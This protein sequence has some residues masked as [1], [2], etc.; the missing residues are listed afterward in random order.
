MPNW[1]S[2]TICVEGGKANLKAFLEAVKGTATIFDFNR[3]IPMPE[4]LKHTGCGRRT[5]DGTAYCSWYQ[6]DDDNGRPFTSAEE[7]VLEEIGHRD[8]YSW[9][10]VNW[11]TKWNA[12]HA[13]ISVNRP[14]QGHIEIT[15]E[16]AWSPPIPV[17]AKM[18]EMFP[19]LSFNFSSQEE[20]CAI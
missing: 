5:I 7:A 2:N 9:A 20:C 12:K 3:I 17:I 15:F 11:G 6:L 13:Q 10:W 18:V 8:W 4:L 16:T 19:A 1:V 14:A